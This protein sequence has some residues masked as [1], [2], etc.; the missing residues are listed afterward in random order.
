MSIIKIQHRYKGVLPHV[1]DDISN[2]GLDYNRKYGRG[3]DP[4]LRCISFAL[5][6]N[7]LLEYGVN[8]N[9]T[10]T[11]TKKLYHD[12]LLNTIHAEADLTMKLLKDNQIHLVTDIVIIRGTS[13]ILSSHPCCVC[14]GLLKMYFNNVRMWYYDFDNNVWHC[15]LI[16]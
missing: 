3:F 16:G 2:M 4:S 14:T 7:K 6:G 8:K 12:H 1:L 9:K 15:E 11:F 5:N 13:K 10:H